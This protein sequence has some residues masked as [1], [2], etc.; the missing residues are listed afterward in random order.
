MLNILFNITGELAGGQWRLGSAGVVLL[1][2][3]V[4]LRP[5]DKLGTFIS[6]IAEYR[7]K[8]KFMRSLKLLF[9]MASTYYM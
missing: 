4:I 1:N 9:N 6:E 2:V 7:K 3:S 8:W 5:V